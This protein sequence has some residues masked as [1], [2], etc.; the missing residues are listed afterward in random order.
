MYTLDPEVHVDY[1]IT[2]VFDYGKW[3]DLKAVMKYY[4][5]ERVKQ[6]LKKASFLLPDTI[7]FVATVFSI[8]P[9]D[10]ACFNNRPYQKSA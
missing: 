7:R 4:G 5:E 9:Q 1:I 10:L 2:K 3:Q 8:K 6:S